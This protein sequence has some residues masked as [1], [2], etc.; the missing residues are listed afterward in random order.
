MSKGRIVRSGDR[1][2]SEMLETKGYGWIGL[3][4]K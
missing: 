2:L 1:E 3:E 4:E